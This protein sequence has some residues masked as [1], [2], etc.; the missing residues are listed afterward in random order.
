[1]QAV[2]ANPDHF[3]QI[4]HAIR[5]FDFEPVAAPQ[6]RQGNTGLR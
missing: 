1:L 3:R 5:C 6:A 4:A 2:S